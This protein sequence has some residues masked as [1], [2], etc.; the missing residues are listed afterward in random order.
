MGSVFNDFPNVLLVQVA[1]VGPAAGQWMLLPDQMSRAKIP[2]W[3]IGITKR[4]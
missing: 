1:V 4:R 2:K 3:R